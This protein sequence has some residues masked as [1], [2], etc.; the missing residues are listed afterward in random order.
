MDPLETAW[1]CCSA[2]REGH[3]APLAKTGI[4]ALNRLKP[5]EMAARES[6]AHQNRKTAFPDDDTPTVTARVPPPDTHTAT[7]HTRMHTRH[8]SMH[9]SGTNHLWTRGAASSGRPGRAKAS[10][11]K[12][13]YR[14]KAA[15]CGRE[16][17]AIPNKQT[18]AA[19][20]TFQH[21]S[22][23]RDPSGTTPV[24]TLRPEVGLGGAAEAA[25]PARGCTLRSGALPALA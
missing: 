17:S 10:T 19:H 21:Q 1:S 25:V 3:R 9:R 24:P 15:Y 5:L 22:R 7:R 20:K 4:A 12:Y 14:L 13:K 16:R 2:R 6:L 18:N 11:P 23:S 8:R